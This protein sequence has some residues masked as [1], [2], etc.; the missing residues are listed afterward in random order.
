MDF[1]MCADLSFVVLRN[2]MFRCWQYQT[3]KWFKWNDVCAYR[4]GVILN[5][6]QHPQSNFRQKQTVESKRELLPMNT[7]P[8]YLLCLIR[9]GDVWW[10]QDKA[11]C[12]HRYQGR[13]DSKT[14]NLVLV[15]LFQVTERTCRTEVG[16]ISWTLTLHLLY[17]ACC[18]TYRQWWQLLGDADI[19]RF[20]CV[21]V[22]L[23][24]H[25]IW[26]VLDKNSVQSKR[27]WVIHCQ[28]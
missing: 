20:L 17:L 10:C 7:F 4:L 18:V 5:R 15:Q 23:Y 19:N 24:V 27:V 9:R 13:S 6:L 12:L 16:G 26:Q 28:H 3:N 22:C 21:C 14:L 8:C 11:D 2:V 25:I 1:R